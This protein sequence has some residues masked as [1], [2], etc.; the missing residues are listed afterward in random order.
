MIFTHVSHTHTQTDGERERAK[1]HIPPTFSYKFL[2]FWS[3]LIDSLRKRAKLPKYYVTFPNIAISSVGL[4]EKTLSNS[5]DD[6][7]LKKVALVTVFVSNFALKVKN[8]KINSL[9]NIIEQ[10]IMS[11]NT[12]PFSLSWCSHFSLK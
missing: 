10:V 12:H 9:Y 3:N 11:H 2:A 6:T 7:I 1:P 4:Y 8:K 5:F